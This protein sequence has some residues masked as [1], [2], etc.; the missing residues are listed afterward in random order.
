MEIRNLEA[1]D[2]PYVAA[3]HVAAFPDSA[4]TMLGTEVVRRYY[5]WQLT[6]P[7]DI[8]ALG[9]FAGAGVEGYCFGG[10]FRGAMSGFFNSTLAIKQL[11]E[12]CRAKA[13]NLRLGN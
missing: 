1:K 9:A 7:H 2:L 6:G 10:V 3:V 4:L 13:Q 5:E 11:R 8:A 12:D